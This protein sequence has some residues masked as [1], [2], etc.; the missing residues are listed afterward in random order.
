[1][2]NKILFDDWIKRVRKNH[3]NADND[4]QTYLYMTV[5]S[6][7]KVIKSKRKYLKLK[8]LNNTG[9]MIEY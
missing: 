2:S 8:L 6:T 7:D 9:M 3:P 4:I 1:M 5:N